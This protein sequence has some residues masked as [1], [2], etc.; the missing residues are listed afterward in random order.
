MPK[1]IVIEKCTACPYIEHR[2]GFGNI[3]Y[4][5]FCREVSCDLPFTV[6]VQQGNNVIATPTGVIPDWCPLVEDK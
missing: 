4:K 2:G 5:P 6:S 1:K 3:M